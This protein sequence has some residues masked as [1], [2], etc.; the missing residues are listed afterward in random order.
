MNKN[1]KDYWR[2]VS[3]L[4]LVLSAI[5]TF[6]IAGEI[7]LRIY[8]FLWWDI[9]VIDGQPRR[10]SSPRIAP[11][12]FDDQLGWRAT[13]NYHFNETKQSFDGTPYFARV[14]QDSR[15]FRLFGELSTSKPKVFVIGDS[16]TQAVEVSDDQTYYSRLKRLL[17][18]EVFAY[19]GG[20]YGTL[21]E[22]LI[23]DKYVDLIKPDIV[24]WQFSNND[25]INN[26]P[27]LEAASTINNNGLV[28][29][30]LVNGHIQYLHP[31]NAATMV[32]SISPRYCRLYYLVDKPFTAVTGEHVAAHGRARYGGR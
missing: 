31:N 8:H 11:I 6:V 1:V 26:A 3:P 23:F 16:M 29:P 20:G 27:D 12:A 22:F 4:L 15:G 19:G 17:D 7:L 13:E 21:Q 28:R 32:P 14:S 10:Q 24:L 18:I 25:I 2:T 30:Y 9:S 5:I